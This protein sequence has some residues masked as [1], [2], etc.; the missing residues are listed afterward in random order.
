MIDSLF[1]SGK[2]IIPDTSI[3]M[4]MQNKKVIKSFV[5]DDLERYSSDD[6]YEEEKEKKEVEKK[7]DNDDDDEDDDDD[8]DDSLGE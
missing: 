2:V 5:E 1:K 7:E 8:H 3:R 6:D 4:Q